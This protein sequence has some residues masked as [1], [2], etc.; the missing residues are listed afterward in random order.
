MLPLPVFFQNPSLDKNTHFRLL[1]FRLGTNTMP[2]GPW[3]PRSEFLSQF[4]FAPVGVKNYGGGGGQARPL[5]EADGVAYLRE[6]TG[7]PIPG[8]KLMVGLTESVRGEELLD[9]KPALCVGEGRIRVSGDEDAMDVPSC[10]MLESDHAA[11]TE[12]VQLLT[13]FEV[14]DDEGLNLDMIKYAATVLAAVGIFA[15]FRLRP[16]ADAAPLAH[17]S[18]T[19][20][21]R[22]MRGETPQARKPWG[23]ARGSSGGAGGRGGGGGRPKRVSVLDP[24]RPIGLHLNVATLEVVQVDTRGQAANVRVGWRLIE[25]I[26]CPIHNRLRS[27]LS[28]CY[29]LLRKPW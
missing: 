3:P 23:A 10:W 28:R 24:G 2:K 16:W 29:L 7:L 4:F 13:D 25:V 12:T 1:L 18:V 5:K 19:K 20:H 26:P 22:R 15:A 14:K 21:R 8:D 6:A 9:W 27:P 17:H 11:L